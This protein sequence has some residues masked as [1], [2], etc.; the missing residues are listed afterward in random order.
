MISFLKWYQEN[1]DAESTSAQRVF[2]L[3]TG[4]VAAL[5]AIQNE[6]VGKR[7]V[8]PDTPEHKEL[9]LKLSESKP[10]E[11]LLLDDRQLELLKDLVE[12]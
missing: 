5:E 8:V 2:D 9:A 1:M 7:Y 6:K 12:L 3:Q 10:G 11:V 4:W